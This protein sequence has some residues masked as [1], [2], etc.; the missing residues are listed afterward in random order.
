QSLEI[1]IREGGTEGQ[2]R[3]RFKLNGTE[4]KAS[5]IVGTVNAVFFAPADVDLIAGSPSVR[6]RFLDVMLCQLDPAY[7]RALSR[8]N[9]V[10]VQRNALLRQ[11]RDRTQPAGS[12][13][14]WDDGLCDYGGRI[15]A[16]RAA[17]TLALGEIAT[18]RHHE[19]S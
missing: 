1:V 10:I 15:V 4:R 9:K 3:K 13:T 5:E 12:L 16:Q 2:T 7:F 18:Q 14:Y 8:Y 19:L 6:R 17:A 11:V